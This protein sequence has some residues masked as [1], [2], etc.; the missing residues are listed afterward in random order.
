M[1]SSLGGGHL[2][3]T[4]ERRRHGLV[5]ILVRHLSVGGRVD[6]VLSSHRA[7]IDLLTLVHGG[8]NVELLLLIKGRHLV[9]LLLLLMLLLLMQVLLLLRHLRA[10]DVEALELLSGGL[11]ISKLLLEELL[12][13]G[14]V[15]VGGNELGIEVRVLEL[16]VHRELRGRK[17]LVNRVLLVQHGLVGGLL[18]GAVLRK[19]RLGRV[20]ERFLAVALQVG[21]H[22]VPGILLRRRRG[23]A[24]GG[25][26]GRLGGGSQACEEVRAACAWGGNAIV[27]GSGRLVDA[28]NGERLDAL[29]ATA[30]R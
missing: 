9:L 5:T 23:W 14:E 25:S 3:I 8:L 2:L 22:A 13:L 11:H 6:I 19:S 4:I 16:L 12:A 18:L 20:V 28:I 21:S 15:H 27:T 1:G 30:R 17:N 29:A 24:E 26:G 10:V 7:V